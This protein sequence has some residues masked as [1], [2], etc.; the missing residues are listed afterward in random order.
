MNDLIRANALLTSEDE[1]EESFDETLD[2]GAEKPLDDESGD[3][4]DMSNWEN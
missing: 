4:V 3:D 1:L 2:D